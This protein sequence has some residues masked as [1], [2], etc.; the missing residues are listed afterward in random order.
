MSAH[1]GLTA[2]KPLPTKLNELDYRR[3]FVGSHVRH[4]IA[5]QLRVLR[6]KLGLSQAE[7]GA[8]MGKPQGNISRAENP[9]YGKHSLE[10]LI[11]YAAVHDVGLSVKFVPFSEMVE[12]AAHMSPHEIIVLNYA[13][14]KAASSAALTTAK[15]DELILGRQ[16][17][18]SNADLLQI[19]PLNRNVMLLAWNNILPENLLNVGSPTGT[20]IKSMNEQHKQFVGM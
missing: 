17:T 18:W 16:N 12:E 8:K 11:E 10:T 6:E 2:S 15:Y 20:Q 4:Y 3:A 14:D 19:Q 9:S 13:E 1:F 7:L 5:A